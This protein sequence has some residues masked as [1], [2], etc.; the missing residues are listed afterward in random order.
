MRLSSQDFVNISKESISRTIDDTQSEEI[1][2]VWECK[3][4]QHHKGLFMT[5]KSKSYWEVTYN[6]DSGEMYIDEYTKKCQTIVVLKGE[7]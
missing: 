6:G 7:E 1:H 3:T 2:V 5:P 4:L